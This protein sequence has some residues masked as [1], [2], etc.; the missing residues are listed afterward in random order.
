MGRLLYFIPVGGVQSRL[1]D[2]F[3]QVTSVPKWQFVLY[4]FKMQMFCSESVSLGRGAA[5]WCPDVSQQLSS[6]CSPPGNPTSRIGTFFFTASDRSTPPSGAP[7]SYTQS[8]TSQRVGRFRIFITSRF[9]PIKSPTWTSPT[10]LSSNRR[11]GP[12][13]SKT[14]R[15][16]LKQPAPP[17]VQTAGV[18]LQA[19]PPKH[20]SPF[21]PDGTVRSGVSES[22]RDVAF[23]GT[24]SASDSKTR[25]PVTVDYGMLRT[26]DC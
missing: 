3:H 2:V 14:E 24:C 26:K 8:K 13:S 4:T 11:S 17:R 15:L 23:T 16:V 21:K 10:T 12:Q 19:P 18:T 22:S 1:Q 9:S 7:V 5:T 20:N 25:S 6:D